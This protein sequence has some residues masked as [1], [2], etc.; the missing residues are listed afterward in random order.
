MSYKKFLPLFGLAFQKAQ[1]KCKILIL[2]KSPKQADHLCGLDLIGTNSLMFTM[3]VDIHADIHIYT[4]I[5]FHN[6]YIIY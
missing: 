5:N 6:I 4:D 2:V 3:L 1:R